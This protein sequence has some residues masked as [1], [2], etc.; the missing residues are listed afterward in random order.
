M[1]C[2]LHLLL[3]PKANQ[4][5]TE[6]L[7]LVVSKER[8]TD[9]DRDEGDIVPQ[10][11]AIS[12]NW[13][14]RRSDVL[15]ENISHSRQKQPQICARN[16]RGAKEFPLIKAERREATQKRGKEGGEKPKPNSTYPSLRHAHKAHTNPQRKRH[17][18][19]DAPWHALLILP[20]LEIVPTN[21]GAEPEMFHRQ[22]HAETD[23]PVAQEGEEVGDEGG[24][25]VLAAPSEAEADGGEEG[26]PHEAR[27]GHE[28]LAP[29]LDGEGG[30]VVDCR[31]IGHW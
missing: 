23:G 17:T 28:V 30:G 14:R 29:E 9:D 19:R 8:V 16:G 21:A 2:R 12:S 22:A 6:N 20:A 25:V 24:E 27:D 31:E 4:S 10:I 15:K 1:S 3:P 26:V 13:S 7:D 18:T 5:S 11:A